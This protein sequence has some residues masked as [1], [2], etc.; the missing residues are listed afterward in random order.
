VD[1]PVELVPLVCVKCD[2]PI[3]T[4]VDEIAWACTQCG[5][6]MVLDEMH[7]LQALNIHYTADIPEDTPGKPYW[8]VDGRVSMQRSTYGRPGES[9]NESNLFWS[10]PRRFFIPAFQ[11][12]LELLLKLAKSML[13]NPPILEPSAPVAFEAVTLNREDV[14]AAA[15]FIVIAIEAGRKDKLKSVNFELQLSEP[16]LWILP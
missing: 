16:V 9:G 1:R 3:P 8:V 13:L 4:G 5:Q 15:E 6:G 2:T 14:L 7:G 12:P 10:K 11:A